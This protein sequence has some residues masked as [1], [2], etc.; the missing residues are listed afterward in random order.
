MR[1]RAQCAI[2]VFDEYNSLRERFTNRQGKKVDQLFKKAEDTDQDTDWESDD[3]GDGEEDGDGAD[4]A[5]D[6]APPTR[7]ISKRTRRRC[8]A[9]LV[10]VSPTPGK[11]RAV[12]PP[13]RSDVS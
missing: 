13:C 3:S 4:V 12:S 8:W 1:A 10:G 11:S 2:G 9:R 7:S 5:M 6:D